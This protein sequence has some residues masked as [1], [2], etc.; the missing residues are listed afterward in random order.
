MALCRESGKAPEIFPRAQKEGF[1]PSHH[2]TN[3]QAPGRVATALKNH[4]FPEKQCKCR[5]PGPMAVCRKGGKA[6]EIFRWSQKDGLLPLH[7]YTN[8]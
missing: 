8:Q 7:P 3:R 4:N 5:D 6:L 2:Y 1:L